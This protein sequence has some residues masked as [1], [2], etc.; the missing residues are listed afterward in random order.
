LAGRLTITGAKAYVNQYIA[1]NISRYNN[2]KTLLPLEL[3]M[4]HADSSTKPSLPTG[5]GDLD[6]QEAGTTMTGVPAEF[7]QRSTP[8]EVPAQAGL[9]P[10]PSNGGTPSG[11]PGPFD[12]RSAASDAISPAG[13]TPSECGCGGAGNKAGDSPQKVYALGKLSFDYGT[14]SRRI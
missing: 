11:E 14:R 8:S 13:L 3:I 10:T 7:D 6:D 12:R 9:A 2:A 1:N 4:K 5:V